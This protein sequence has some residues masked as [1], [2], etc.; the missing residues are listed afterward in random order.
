MNGLKIEVCF[1]PEEYDSERYQGWNVVVIDVLR[2]T[3]SIAVAFSN[4]CNMIVPAT[5]VEEAFDR[6]DQEYRQALL[7]GER[8]GVLI[9]GFDMGNSPFEFTKERIAGQD[10]IMT[11]TNGTVALQKSVGAA[12]VY[13][14]ALVNANAVCFELKR[15]VRDTVI[16]CAGTDGKFSVE[17]TVCAGLIVS[18]LVDAAGINATLEDKA[19]VSRAL[20]LG[21]KDRLAIEVGR[22][23][24]AQ[25]LSNIGFQNDVSFCLQQDMIQ[26]VPVY[27]EGVLRVR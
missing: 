12:N 13:T 27:A 1:T 6:K 11:T 4:G 15:E 21:I 20:Y 25:Y 23:S 8:K 16:L 22:S 3:T 5:I 17:D 7:A 14:A 26:I 10:I 18:N 19:L 2:A 9:P 24:H